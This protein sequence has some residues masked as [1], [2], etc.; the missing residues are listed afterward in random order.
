[1]YVRG[2]NKQLYLEG[3]FGKWIVTVKIRIAIRFCPTV[4][5]EKSYGSDPERPNVPNSSHPYWAEQVFCC[6]RN[7][8]IIQSIITKSISFALE[9]KWHSLIFPEMQQLVIILLQSPNLLLSLI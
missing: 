6:I 1:M 5:I 2:F 4:N 9:T 3:L 7:K 8:A